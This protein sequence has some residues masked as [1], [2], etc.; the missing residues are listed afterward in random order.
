MFSIFL[1]FYY[2]TFYI[3][4]FL[5]SRENFNVSNVLF[6][7]ILLDLIQNGSLLSL[8]IFLIYFIIFNI[9]LFNYIIEPDSKWIPSFSSFSFLFKKI[10]MLPMYFPSII[11]LDLVQNSL[12]SPQLYYWIKFKIF[13]FFPLISFLSQKKFQYF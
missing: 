12:F 6:F 4:S 3:S 8:H 9:F 7:N 11:F 13:P 10:S 5:L 2:T 1:Q